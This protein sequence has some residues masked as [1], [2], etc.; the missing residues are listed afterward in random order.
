MD[1]KLQNHQK[2]PIFKA[3]QSVRGWIEVQADPYIL[4]HTLTT[5]GD[6]ERGAPINSFE[7]R[8]AAALQANKGARLLDMAYKT[9]ASRFL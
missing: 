6:Q 5:P 3:H 7:G 2:L 8:S 9:M 4:I 1:V